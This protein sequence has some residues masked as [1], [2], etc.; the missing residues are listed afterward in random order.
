MSKQVMI[1]I[2]EDGD[3][4]IE[5]QGYSGTSC[6]EATQNL[7]KALG[8]KDKRDYKPEYHNTQA[9]EQHIHQ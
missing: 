9:Q 3:F 1:T 7:E 6:E 2:A 8:K 5:A 4:T